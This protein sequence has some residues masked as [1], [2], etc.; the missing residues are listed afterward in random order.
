[1]RIEAGLNYP[2]AR[3]KKE[4]ATVYIHSHGPGGGVI[5]HPARNAQRRLQIY[6]K[7]TDRLNT[8]LVGLIRSS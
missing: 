1:V 2:A 3:E 5:R 6:I 4:K 8:E 7:I